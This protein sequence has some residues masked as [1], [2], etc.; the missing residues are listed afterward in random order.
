MEEVLPVVAPEPAR[1]G[2]VLPVGAPYLGWQE[3]PKARRT[4]IEKWVSPMEAG[5]LYTQIPWVQR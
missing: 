3:V 1:L 2:V 5:D 4:P